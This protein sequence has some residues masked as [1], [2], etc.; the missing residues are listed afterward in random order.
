MARLPRATLV[1]RLKA[2]AEDVYACWTIPHN[3]TQW[4]AGGTRGLAQ[5]DVR[6]GGNFL[7]AGL[8]PAGEAFEDWGVY[9]VVLPNEV[10]E[11]SWCGDPPYASRVTMQ[12]LPLAYTTEITLVHFDLPDDATCERQ[13][14]R[15]AAGL[16][17]METLLE[18][19]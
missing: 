18:T 9:T 3:I 6:R 16:E 19:R 4:W 7:V 13:T 8:G 5:C 14:A 2:T 10:L 1:R 12:L 15:W 11:F 17:A